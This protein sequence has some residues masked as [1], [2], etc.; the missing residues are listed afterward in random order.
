MHI[1]PWNY[2]VPINISM[3]PCNIIICLYLHFF[4]LSLHIFTNTHNCGGHSN[5][6]KTEFIKIH[7]SSEQFTLISNRRCNWKLIR[8][9]KVTQMH[10][11]FDF[12]T[13]FYKPFSST[14]KQANTC[15]T[16][17]SHQPPNWFSCIHFLEPFS[18][19]YPEQT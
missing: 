1:F 17:S 7:K 12:L 8:L 18:I 19:K 9:K 3:F 10:C 5:D 6:S 14:S 13:T 2:I 15:T 4:I 11:Y 16:V